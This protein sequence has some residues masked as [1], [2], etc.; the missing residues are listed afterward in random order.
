MWTRPGRRAAASKARLAKEF[1]EIVQWDILFHKR[2]RIAHLIDEAIR[3]TSAGTLS[4]QTSK[5]IT[6]DITRRWLQLFGAM[7]VLVSDQE[8][9]LR[10]DEANTWADHW[11]IH[12]KDKEPGTHAQMVERH[13]AVLRKWSR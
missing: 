11:G 12:L 4:G 2:T 3:W 6:N 1:D 10:S 7:K 9:G 13:H 5:E 8:S